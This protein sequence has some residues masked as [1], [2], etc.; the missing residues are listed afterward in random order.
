LDL[1]DVKKCLAPAPGVIRAGCTVGFMTQK[2]RA[3]LE[4]GLHFEVIRLDAIS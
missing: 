3:R 2:G 1:L 4:H